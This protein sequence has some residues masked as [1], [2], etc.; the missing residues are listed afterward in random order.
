MRVAAMI[1]VTN[2][3]SIYLWIAERSVVEQMTNA[4]APASD[5]SAAMTVVVNHSHCKKRC[6]S[7]LSP[8]YPAFT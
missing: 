5:M 7:F 8:W 2:A 1:A 3:V 4:V 6:F